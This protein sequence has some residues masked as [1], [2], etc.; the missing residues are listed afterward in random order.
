MDRIPSF[1]K[2]HDLLMPGLYLSTVQR[3]IATFDL[4]FK[5][6][7]AGDYVSPKASHSIEHMLATVLRNGPYRENIVYFGPM[8]C[9]TGFYLLTAGMTCAQVLAELKRA[10]AEALA[11][12][13][14]PG[15]EKIECGNYLEHDLDGAKGECRAYLALL[16]TLTEKDV[17]AGAADKGIVL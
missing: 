9:R 6:P 13:R 3:G 10:F 8:G 12:D 14:V 11:L 4:R 2:N 5:K 17:C 16:D 15:A 7:N 1:E